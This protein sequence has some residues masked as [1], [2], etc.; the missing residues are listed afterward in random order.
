MD[1][2][3]TF[4]FGAGIALGTGLMY[5]LDSETGL[6]RRAVIRNKMTA[7]FKCSPANGHRAAAHRPEL[8]QE[9]I[10]LEISRAGQ[11]AEMAGD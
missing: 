1:S 8:T 10:E 9:D 7:A 6:K 5:L 3:M 4:A 2:K 11:V